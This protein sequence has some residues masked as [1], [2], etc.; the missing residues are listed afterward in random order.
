M[1][2]HIRGIKDNEFFTQ[3]DAAKIV[4]LP[5]PYDK[6][7][8]WIK[9]ADKG[10]FAILEAFHSLET[11]D[12]ETGYDVTR[13]GIYVSDAVDKDLEPEEMVNQV[14]KRVSHFLEDGPFVVTLG[15]EHSVSVGAISAYSEE[16]KD[17]SVLQLDAH[18]DLRDE[19]EGS[20]YNHACCMARV[21][22]KVPNLVQVG[23]RSSSGGE[24][25][26]IEADKFF[27]A[28]II[29]S[30]NNWIN[31]AING[32]SRNVYVTIDLDVFDPAVMP[33]TG[34]PQPG[35]LSWETVTRF[36]K[37][38]AQERNIVGFDVVELCPIDRFKAPNVLAAKLV[39][40]LLG[41][42]Y[43]VKR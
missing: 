41:Y 31:S 29:K 43:S 39:Y 4:M 1:E 22:E 33:S 15:G 11:H 34:T 38:T 27:P 21:K 40:K 16:Y 23:V 30:D 12:L 8:T 28:H 14:K 19:Y 18:T 3:K 6:T 42:I 32:L 36:L 17:L 25:K 7:S 13:E 35:G 2:D 26:Q 10:P 5:V 24:Q 37:K 9:G 20:K